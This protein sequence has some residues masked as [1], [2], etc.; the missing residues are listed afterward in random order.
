MYDCYWQAT[1]PRSLYFN[2]SYC[3]HLSPWHAFAEANQR[4]FADTLSQSNH[5]V[6]LFLP[7]FIEQQIPW[8]QRSWPAENVKEKWW[9]R[10]GVTLDPPVRRWSFIPASLFLHHWLITLVSVSLP[11]YASW[12][13][14][15]CR[16][17]YCT[18]NVGLLHFLHDECGH[19]FWAFVSLA[20]S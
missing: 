9:D 12:F 8:L 20:A 4:E 6:H 7:I 2:F 17:I 13:V 3:L 19:P 1:Y 10:E 14:I 18:V 15:V 16:L 11:F 5:S